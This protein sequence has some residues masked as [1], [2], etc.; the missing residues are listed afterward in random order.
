MIRA[1]KS[2]RPTLTF[3]TTPQRRILLGAFR[4]RR[5][6]STCD[7]YAVERSSTTFTSDPRVLWRALVRLDGR[8][9]IISRHRT[10]PAAER[11]CRSHCRK[12]LTAPDRP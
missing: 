9:E 8:W 11:A 4:Y 10:R 5:F 12:A 1:T 7:R 2:T 6:I 3:R